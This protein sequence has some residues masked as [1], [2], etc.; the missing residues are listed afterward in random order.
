MIPC[1][2]RELREWPGVSCRYENRGKHRSIV[3]RFDGR[4]MF[5]VC[6]KT[7]SDSYHG[8]R[9]LVAG[10]RVLLRELGAER[11][12]RPR[13][14]RDRFHSRRPQVVNHLKPITFEARIGRDPWAAL[15]GLF[16]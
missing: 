4:E 14:L 15:R 10:V 16:R 13:S 7:P 2:E 9:N 1:V 8:Q 3:F 11:R 6:A 12:K 5:Y